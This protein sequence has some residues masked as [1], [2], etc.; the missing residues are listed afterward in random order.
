MDEVQIHKQIFCE[1]IYSFYEYTY[2]TWIE[3]YNFNWE[4]FVH[5]FLWEHE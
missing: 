1:L 5:E 4:I 3:M 2:Y